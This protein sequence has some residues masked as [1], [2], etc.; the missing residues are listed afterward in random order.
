MGREP[1]G[2]RCQTG[3]ATVGNKLAV[4]G[5]KLIPCGPG[6]KA[7][8]P[9]ESGIRNL[10]RAMHRCLGMNSQHAVKQNEPC[11][12]SPRLR[13]GL[14][15]GSRIAEERVFSGQRAVTIG[16]AARSTF[17]MPPSA[18]PRRWTLFRWRRGRCLLRLPPGTQGRVAVGAKIRALGAVPDAGRAGAPSLR[19]VD[20]PPLSRGK[21]SLGDTTVLFQ[22]VSVP[23]RAQPRLPSSVRGSFWGTVDRVFVSFVVLSFAAHLGLLV[24]LRRVDWPRHP[25]PEQMFGTFREHYMRRPPTVL[26]DS[27]S[28]GAQPTTKPT[29][30]PVVA[31]TTARPAVANAGPRVPLR[32]QVGRTIFRR[33]AWLPL[34]R[35]TVPVRAGFAVAVVLCPSSSLG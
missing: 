19:E 23:L 3:P 35:W 31:K 33:F 17:V 30:K 24:Y 1:T 27:P 4:A 10:A 28:P 32:T 21:V 15:M 20:L 25:D 13:V 26:P 18:L 34:I 22:L 2:L 12:R 9:Q 11:S 8:S 6:A 5:S 7:N 29:H 16:S 14:V